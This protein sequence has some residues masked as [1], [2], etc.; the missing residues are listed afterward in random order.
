VTGLV[1]YSC[2]PRET[3]GAGKSFLSWRIAQSYLEIAMIRAAEEG[4]ELAPFHV[5]NP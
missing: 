5:N 2:A 4:D 3:N 1:G